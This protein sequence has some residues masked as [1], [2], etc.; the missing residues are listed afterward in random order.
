MEL[1]RPGGGSRR[2][3]ELV[4]RALGLGASSLCQLLGHMMW[5]RPFPDIVQV[6]VTALYRALCLAL[7]PP[8]VT[9][10]G[11]ADMCDSLA[12]LGGSCESPF[13]C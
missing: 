6:S 8:P 5:L 1:K 4:V 12:T 13:F 7:L 2:N 11:F 3:T 10:G 9:N